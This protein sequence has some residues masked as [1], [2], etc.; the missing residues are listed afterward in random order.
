ML[1][2][3][4]DDYFPLGAQWDVSHQIWRRITS[5]AVRIGGPNSTRRQT[6]RAQL[7]RSV[8][9]AIL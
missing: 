7:D 1:Q 5:L 4:G 8:T 2:K 6:L 3:V 9:A